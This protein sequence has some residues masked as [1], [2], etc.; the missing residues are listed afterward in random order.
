MVGRGL[1]LAGAGEP[2][3]GPP[4]TFPTPLEDPRVLC[5][6]FP[7]SHETPMLATQLLTPPPQILPP[8]PLGLL[9][10]SSP[11]PYACHLSL[12]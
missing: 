4:D 5:L 11:P 10:T 12:R 7:S 6:T 9:P 2:E 8:V 3:W 1:D